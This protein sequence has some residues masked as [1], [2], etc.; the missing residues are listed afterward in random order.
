VNDHELIGQRTA[1]TYLHSPLNRNL[2]T[3][4]M[5]NRRRSYQNKSILPEICLRQRLVT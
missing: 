1:F 2:I 4:P 5:V 3:A